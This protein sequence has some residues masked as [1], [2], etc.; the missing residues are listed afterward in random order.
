MV[1]VIIFNFIMLVLLAILVVWLINK[2]HHDKQINKCIIGKTG[3][4]G[5]QCAYYFL[6]Q[7]EHAT[8]SSENQY[9][10][11]DRNYPAAL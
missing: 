6:Y 8:I 10:G 1:R 9:Y 7:K 11:G 5:S 3:K 4:P 2:A